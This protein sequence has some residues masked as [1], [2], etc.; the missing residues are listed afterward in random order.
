ME[1]FYQETAVQFYFENTD[2]QSQSSSL[3]KIFLLINKVA[4]VTRQWLHNSKYCC[5]NISLKALSSQFYINFLPV[6]ALASFTSLLSSTCLSAVRGGTNHRDDN[7]IQKYNM[8]FL[9]VKHSIRNQQFP[10][11]FT[12]V[13]LSSLPIP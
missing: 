10:T 9:I 6:T 4:G 1:D 7:K 3:E 12:I 2:I 13:F 11:I 5:K 8:K